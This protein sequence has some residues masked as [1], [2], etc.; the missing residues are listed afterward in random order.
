MHGS[1]RLYERTNLICRT[2]VCMS[3]KSAF[4]LDIMTNLDVC[5]PYILS[6]VLHHVVLG[7]LPSTI[8][9]RRKYLKDIRFWPPIF[10]G[11]RPIPQSCPFGGCWMECSRAGV[12]TR[13][14]RSMCAAVKQYAACEKLARNKRLLSDAYTSIIHITKKHKSAMHSVDVA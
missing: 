5:T 4:R 10:W 14:S 12:L 1:L 11:S 13:V 2:C 8:N 3:H 7:S 9:G 6:F